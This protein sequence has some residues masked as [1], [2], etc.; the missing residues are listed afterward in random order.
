MTYYDL[1]NTFKTIS[2]DN[3]FV[4]QFGYGQVTDI[5][6]PA[7]K[8]APDYP[9]VFLNP[10]N[11]SV[12]EKTS[13]A[14]FNL[15]CMEQVKDTEDSIIKGQSECIEIIMWIVS[16]FALYL[17]YPLIQINTPFSV[18]PF[19]EAYNDTVV[20]ATASLTITYNNPYNICNPPYAS[21]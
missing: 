14:T 6:L 18:T 16:R 1:V 10:V 19:K 8:D 21:L 9:Y 2:L 12:N 17:D 5:N 15:I 7:D 11:L 4:N 20:G 13:Q 3:R